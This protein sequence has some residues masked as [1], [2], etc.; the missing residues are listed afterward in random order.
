MLAGSDRRHPNQ[1]DNLRISLFCRPACSLPFALV[2]VRNRMLN[3]MS[4]H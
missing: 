1:V 2:I 3:V 4:D